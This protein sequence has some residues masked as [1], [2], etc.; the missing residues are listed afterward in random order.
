MAA[1]P[2]TRWGKM[3]REEEQV[4]QRVWKQVYCFET[5]TL[6]HC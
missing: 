1:F 2:G 4:M 3:G 6:L 5:R